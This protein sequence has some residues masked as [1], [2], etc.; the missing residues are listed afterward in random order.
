MDVVGWSDTTDRAGFALASADLDQSTAIDIEERFGLGAL[1][2]HERTPHKVVVDLRH[3]PRSP[4]DGRDRECRLGVQ[5]V[6][7]VVVGAAGTFL[8]GEQ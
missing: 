8:L 6:P 7:G 2:H 1:K 3:L 4:D 5:G